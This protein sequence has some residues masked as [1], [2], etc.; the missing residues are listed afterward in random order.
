M[1]AF[2]EALEEVA[3]RS[4]ENNPPDPDDPIIDGLHYCRKC[5]QQTEMVIDIGGTPVTVSV[6]CD[7][8]KAQLEEEEKQ[9]KY[10]DAMADIERLQSASLLTEKYR[11]ASFDA[12]DRVPGNAKAYRISRNYCERF[13]GGGDKPGMLERNQGLLFYGTVGSGKSYTAACIANDLMKRRVTVLMT[14]FVRILQ[15]LQ[16]ETREA[17]YVDGIIRPQLLIIDDLGAERSTD[18]ALEKVYNVIDSRVRAARPMVLTTN[19]TMQQ[20]TGE[21]DVRLRRI[22]DRIL[23][24]CYPVQITGQSFRM[25]SAAQRQ[26]EMRELLEE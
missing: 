22:Y 12:Y 18:Y 11:Q 20:I 2:D 15:D 23:E 24:C 19:L 21:Q 7:C 25:K 10:R 26:V 13:L 5:G 3:R 9:R 4:R 14:S 16:A 6:V 1:K 17:A 8:K